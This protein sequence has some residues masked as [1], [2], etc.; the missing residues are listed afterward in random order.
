MGDPL[1]GIEVEIS[2][3]QE[4]LIRALRPEGLKDGDLT[5]TIGLKLNWDHLK[6]MAIYQGV[7]PL[8]YHRLTNTE[9]PLLPESERPSWRDLF[10]INAQRNLRLN[11]KLLQILTFLTQQ[12]IR[13][14]PIKGPVLA[15]QAYGDHFPK[16][17][18]RP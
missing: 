8:L 14:I 11:R 10:L 4:V 15:L 2:R 13:A 7:F 3:E 16:A 18:H 1:S 6:E 17:I 9:P 12:G 5:E